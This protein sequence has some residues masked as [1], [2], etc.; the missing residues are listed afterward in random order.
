MKIDLFKSLE[1]VEY[2]GDVPESFGLPESQVETKAYDAV[3]YWPLLPGFIDEMNETCGTI[4][5]IGD[6]D[7]LDA[8]KCESLVGLIDSIGR[9]ENELM[10]A[11]IADLRAAASRAIELGTGIVVEL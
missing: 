2:Y 9:Q 3:A 11:F 1:N 5:D 7:Y 8:A 4:L 10:A 6:V